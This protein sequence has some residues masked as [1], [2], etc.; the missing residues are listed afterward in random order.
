[1]HFAHLAE[2]VFNTPW[3]ITPAAA[4]LACAYLLARINGANDGEAR[5]DVEGLQTP[6][7]RGMEAARSKPYFVDQGIAIVN[8]SGKLVNRGGY[9]DA[10]SGVQSYE[11]LIAKL[12]VADD[13]AAV[14]GILLQLDTPGGEFAGLEALRQQLDGMKRKPVWSIGNSAAASAG[15]YLGAA[16]ERFAMI[17]QG[18]TGSIG[19]VIILRDMS[20]AMEKAG[21]GAT[22]VRSGARKAL[23]SGLEPHSP[24]LIERMQSLV[25]D[26]GD[27]F[28]EFVAERRGIKAEK[29]RALEGD[30][31]NS[32]EA[33]AARLIDAVATVSDF[34]ASMVA[35]VRKGTASRASPAANNTSLT[36][37]Q[38]VMTDF[39]HTQADVDAAKASGATLGAK[40]ERSRIAAILGCDEAKGKQTLA[41][42]LAFKTDG[43]LDDAK[44]LLVVAA[45]ETPAKT[46]LTPEQKM[47]A[48][49]DMLG[50]DESLLH[51][52]MK[53][54]TNPP[55]SGAGGNEPKEGEPTA[56]DRVA[57]LTAQGEA[58]YGKPVAGI[59]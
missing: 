44:G 32:E 29:V 10:L 38:K 11:S 30:A 27:R 15:Y 16:T 19:A 8:V 28:I 57:K 26:A 34:H 2:R 52:A 13:D 45:A 20:R 23:G 46:E 14:N 47:K 33:K 40:E 25:S 37:G 56:A 49:A 53:G 24:E 48:A 31:L 59:R 42:H 55:I 54:K 36:K 22:I 6:L 51:A 4:D 3:F 12:Q 39:T 43:S 21:I 58:T 1:M 7:K 17:P 18:I 50:A 5:I 35:A 41:A 9:M